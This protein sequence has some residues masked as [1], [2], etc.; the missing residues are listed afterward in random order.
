MTSISKYAIVQMDE[1]G[2]PFSP[3]VHIELVAS[4]SRDL[5]TNREI[6]EYVRQLKSDLDETGKQAKSALEKAKTQTAK[7]VAARNSN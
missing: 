1:D 3:I 6:D 7:F 4:E 5:M 2:Q